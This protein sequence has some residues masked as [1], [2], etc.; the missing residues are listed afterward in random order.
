MQ[1]RYIKSTEIRKFGRELPINEKSLTIWSTNFPFLTA[2]HIPSGKEIRVEF[3]SPPHLLLIVLL[4][5]LPV[6]IV[7]N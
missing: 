6:E 2:D 3:Y 7:G 1:N 4:Q 5:E